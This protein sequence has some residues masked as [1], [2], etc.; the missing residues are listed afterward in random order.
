MLGGIKAETI[1]A[2]IEKLLQMPL[3]EVLHQLAVQI[4]IRQISAELAVD[5]A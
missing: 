4:E 1:D 3:L 2:E 5:F